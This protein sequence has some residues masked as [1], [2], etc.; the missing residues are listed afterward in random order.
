MSL[1]QRLAALSRHPRARHPILPLLAF[2]LISVASPEFYP[3]SPFSM[4]SNPSP[5]PMRVVYVRD[6]E[7]RPLPIQALSGQSPAALTKSY[8][9]KRERIYDGR[10]GGEPEL[11]SAD[12][13]RIRREVGEEI[14]RFVRRRAEERRRELPPGLQLVEIIIGADSQGLT[15]TRQVV[16][17]QPSGDPAGVPEED[18]VVPAQP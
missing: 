15:E 6:G 17:L 9:N 2:I 11:G 5:V 12:D 3:L 18:A 13:L 1:A 16:A 8:K 7:G 14:L 10:A 4:Y